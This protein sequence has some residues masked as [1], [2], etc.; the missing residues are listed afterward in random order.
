MYTIEQKIVHKHGSR[1][2]HKPLIIADHISAATMGSMYNTFS[3]P[4]SKSASSTFG[5]S[6]KGEIVQYVPIDRAPWTQGRIQKPKAPIISAMKVNPNLY[7]VSIEHEGYVTVD[8]ETS[9]VKAYHGIK[10]DVT[11][12]QYAATRWLHKYIQHEVQ[13]LYG[14]RIALDAA[15]VLGHFQIDSIGKPFCPGV[16]FPWSQLYADLAKVD[17]MTL[18]EAEEYWDYFNTP[19]AQTVEIVALA[20]RI[21][22][23]KGKLSGKWGK[24]AQRKIEMFTAI[25]VELGISVFGITTE[26]RISGL[27]EEYRT[28]GTHHEEAF[29]KLILIAQ[30]AKKRNLL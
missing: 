29:R 25:L 27:Y 12:E 23:L 14:H 28:K 7:A 22:D 11:P 13:R 10:G 9:A 19:N 16:L 26:D 20:S 1:N 6:R 5:V 4:R 18:A 3:N 21:A 24:E 8:E 2:G 30:E 15:H 17:S